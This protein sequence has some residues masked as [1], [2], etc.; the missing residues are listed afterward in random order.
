MTAKPH[1]TRYLCLHG[2]FYQPPRENPWLEVIEEEEGA[3]P[4]HDWNERI[5]AECYGPNARSRILDERGRVAR[6]SNNYARISFNFGPTLLSWIK[7]KAPAVLKGLERAD[8]QSRRMMAGHGNALAQPYAHIIAPLA[9]PR[10]LET[11]IRWG[12]TAFEFYFGRRPEGMWLPET[13]V[14]LRT[15]ETLAR[16]GILFT[17]LAPHQAGRF[18]RVGKKEWLPVEKG[19]DTRRPY[20]CP[21]PSGKR[22][23]LFFFDGALAHGIA[24]QDLLKNGDDYYRRLTEA[25]DPEDPGPQ[26]VHT[27]T[28]GETYGHHRR[29]GDMALAYALHRLEE[30]PAVTLTNYGRFLKMFPPRQ[31]VEIHEGTSWS[32]AHGIERWR[33]DCGCRAGG[34]EQHQRWRA[35]LREGLDRLKKALDDLFEEKGSRFLKDPWSAREAYVRVILDRAPGNV[36]EYFREQGRS[37]KLPAADRVQAL[38]LL[39]MQRHGLLMFTSCGWFFDDISGLETTQILK[40]ACRAVQLARD[41]GQDLE[42]L[43][44]E[45]LGRAPGN[46]PEFADGQQVWEKLIRP[47]AVELPQVLAHQ[48]VSSIYQAPEARSRV[49][50]FDL[51]NL[52]PIVRR[53]NGTRLALG[54]LRVRSLLTEE[55]LEM[56]YGVLHFGG[57]D[58]HCRLRPFQG[59]KRY[60]AGREELLERYRSGSMGEVYDRLKEIFGGN[61]Y[62]LKNLFREERHRLI[63][64][65]LKERLGAYHKQ[66]REWVSADEGVIRKLAEWQVPLPPAMRS[67]LKHSINQA[68]EEALGDESSPPGRWEVLGRLVRRMEKLGFPVNREQLGENLRSR[69]EELL[70]R[71]PGHPHPGTLFDRLRDLLRGAQGLGLPINLWSVQDAFLDACLLADHL[72]LGVREGYERL[73][74]EMELGKDVLP[75]N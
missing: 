12:I 73:A 68:W 34:W 49:Y 8:R 28:D 48:A 33:S 50:C 71:L 24:F 47:A 58:F 56:I 6:I 54:R 2:H 62:S 7:E 45:H 46:R 43:L 37:E 14:D 16:E 75:F 20:W 38:K 9:D 66:F 27:A 26:L 1:A 35:P 60:E 11:Q 22:I 67:V 29:F 69:I 31:E 44:L 74:A 21:L 19:L 39:E 18:R 23:A 41:F 5:S 61:P 57:L 52:D 10:D 55:E 3:A 72:E 30:D 36:D 13:A 53:Q 15:L 42:P 70:R 59:R 64:L 32:C 51:T 17:I 40:Y 65:I 25:F 4:Y 63:D